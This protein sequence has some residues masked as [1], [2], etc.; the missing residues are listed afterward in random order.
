[1]IGRPPRYPPRWT[2]IEPEVPFG[3]KLVPWQRVAF[4]LLHVSVDD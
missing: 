3:V 1:M 2:T 4:V